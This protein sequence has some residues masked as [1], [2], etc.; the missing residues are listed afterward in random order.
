ME[1]FSWVQFL[2]DKIFMVEATHENWQPQ[3]FCHLDSLQKLCVCGYHVY[4]DIWEAAVGETLV[5]VREPRNAH[6]SN[7]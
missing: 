5:C 3:K 4:N 6:D 2:R 1:K 7:T